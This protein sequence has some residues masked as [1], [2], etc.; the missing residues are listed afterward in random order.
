M[1]SNVI[2]NGYN[3][4]VNQGETFKRF[5]K[6]FCKNKTTGKMR[7]I[8]LEGYK[9]KMQIRKIPQGELIL[10]AETAIYENRITVYLTREQ[11]TNIQAT[12]SEW[13]YYQK[14]VYDII[15]DNGKNLYRI[16]NGLFL[17]SPMTTRA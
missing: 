10:E 3:F 17:V 9:A 5:I 1:D 2:Q 7:P 12:G 6:I 8:N 14:Y 4:K 11:M 15:L 13:Q 16:M